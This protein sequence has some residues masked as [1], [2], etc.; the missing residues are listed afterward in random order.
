MDKKQFSRKWFLGLLFLFGGLCFI[1]VLTVE[2]K[3]TVGLFNKY[4]FSGR[5]IS[6]ALIGALL[7]ILLNPAFWLGGIILFLAFRKLRRKNK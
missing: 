1:G 3:T 6:A 5:T 4:G 7:D 2:L